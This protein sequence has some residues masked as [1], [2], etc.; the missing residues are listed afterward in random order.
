MLLRRAVS[1]VK[2]ILCCYL[3]Y[4]LELKK[5]VLK[6]LKTFIMIQGW[7]IKLF[8]TLSGVI[9][10]NSLLLDVAY[11]NLHQ[12]QEPSQKIGESWSRLG[13]FVA[14]VFDA[15]IVQAFG[16][17]CSVFHSNSIKGREMHEMIDCFGS[18]QT[19]NL[20][21]MGMAIPHDIKR[22]WS[23]A[24]IKVLIWQYLVLS[25]NPTHDWTAEQGP[26]ATVEVT[27]AV[28]KWLSVVRAVCS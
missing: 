9:H 21:G 8:P 15:V 1:S 7:Q 10:F 28:V 27:S 6:I 16:G 4:L 12:L 19:L 17:Y 13:F 23:H 11:E 22:F 2:A 26:V 25:L 24:Y 5:E 18:W 20:H 3:N 14:P